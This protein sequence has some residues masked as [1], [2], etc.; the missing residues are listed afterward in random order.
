MEIIEAEQPAVCP[1]VAAESAQLE[2]LLHEGEVAVH[3]LL[4]GFEADTVFADVERT[5]ALF[6]PAL[7]EVEVANNGRLLIFGSVPLYLMSYH[8]TRHI[9]QILMGEGMRQVVVT[10][11]DDIPFV[12]REF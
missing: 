3:L 8:R 2:L 11:N 9:L 12:F 4:V 10:L 6:A 7:A 5:T 1:D